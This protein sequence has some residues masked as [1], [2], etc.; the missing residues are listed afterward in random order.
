MPP[1]LA[2][3][4]PTETLREHTENC[5]AVYDSLRERMPFLAEVAKEPD[6]FEHLFYTV[7]LHDFGK[8]AVGFQRQLTTS[9]RWNY[10]H[11]I[12][13]AGFV[14]SLQ[15]PLAAKQAVALSILTHHKDIETLVDK[16]PCWPESNPGF[17]T[18]KERIAEL[19]PNWEALM[20]IQE[21]VS[22]WCPTEECLWT[23]VTS[24]EKLM[25]SYRDFLLSYWNNFED[26]ELTPLHGTYGMLLRG[27][28]IA[29]DHLAS[30]GKNEIPTALGNMENRL[31]QFV[32]ERAKGQGRHFRGWERFQETSGKITGQL[33]LSAPTGSGK[34]EAA[35]LWSANNQME[36]LGNRVFYVLPYTASINAMYKR[37]TELVSDEKIGVLH[38]KATYFV[39]QVLVDKDYAPQ[40]AAA[41]ARRE[42]DLTRKICRPYKVLT[43][44]QLLKAFF[45]IRGFEMQ[46]AEMSKGLFIFDEIHAYDPHMTALILTM[47]ERLHYD[48]DAK[49]CI[50][51]A[52]MPQFL[53]QMFDQV[54]GEMSHVEMPA[55]ERDQF[56]RHRI[57]LLDGNIHDAISLIEEQ[58]AQEQR[59]LVVCNTVRQ[60]QTVFKELQYVAENPKLLHSR[61]ILRDR[62]RI[63]KGLDD[64][65]LLV[66]T[67]AV[68]VSLD[69]DFDCLF[70]EPAPIDALIQRF[71]RIN[72]KREKGLCDVCICR[73]GGE[74]DH[75]IYSSAKIRR[76]L[77]ALAPID[78]LYESK[79]QSL[80][81]EVYCHGYDEKEQDKFNNAR[82]AFERHL[83]SVVPFIEDASNRKEFNQLFKSV[84]V[85]PAVY[86]EDFLAEVT[87]RQYYEARAYVAQIS[88]SQFV[89][90]HRDGQLYEN[91]RLGQWFVKVTYDETLGL[92]VDEQSTN[93]L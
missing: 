70:S 65:D 38:G 7:A 42:Q 76:T 85:V 86:E 33:M 63:E 61:F 2:K 9:T 39:Y 69:I 64:A 17:Q 34:T 25:N 89:R 80:I 49:F 22:H 32:E 18:W 68:E 41:L 53:K 67:Q 14:V 20:A 3:S 15:L 88:Y 58:L 82:R 19:E 52:T 60:T 28:T 87:A 21:Q 81:D 59:V 13:S 57:R 37:L 23:P 45:G 78:V 31:S 46:K 11:E 62:E 5:L 54:L 10:R 30:A 90:L 24:V 74:S 8:A 93:I 48:Y 27:C 47:L 91:E 56:T 26:N 12:L 79:I 44:F 1:L 66:G 29:C 55:T 40:D 92:L 73:E 83:Q 75:F 4:D 72:R 36:T 16:Y 50:M 77:R 51:T 43:P 6:F 84:E 71:G 35:L